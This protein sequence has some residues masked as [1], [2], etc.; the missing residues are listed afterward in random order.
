MLADF[1]I[2]V[3]TSNKSGFQFLFDSCPLNLFSASEKILGRAGSESTCAKRK[4]NFYEKI[5]YEQF[6]RDNFHCEQQLFSNLCR[7][8]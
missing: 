6:V 5:F 7:N 3:N 8:S 1:C 2:F 4:S